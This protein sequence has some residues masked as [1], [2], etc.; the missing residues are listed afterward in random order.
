MIGALTRTEHRVVQVLMHAHRPVSIPDLIEAA[1][2]GRK[3]MSAYYIPVTIHHIR[4]K[5]G[6]KINIVNIK[7][8]GYTIK[9]SAEEK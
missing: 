3:C 1:T 8:V 9:T 5:V 7:D 4:R 6:C 2:L